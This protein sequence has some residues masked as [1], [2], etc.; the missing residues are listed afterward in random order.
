[1][2]CAG[3]VASLATA[4]KTVDKSGDR[5]K[6]GQKQVRKVS[7]MLLD[8]LGGGEQADEWWKGTVLAEFRPTMRLLGMQSSN[9]PVDSK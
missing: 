4:R 2:S 5:A 1:M 3:A 9:Q 8:G 7:S 6:V